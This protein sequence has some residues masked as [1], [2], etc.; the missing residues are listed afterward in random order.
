MAD[1][2]FKI[3]KSINLEPLAS[4]TLN[5]E[6]DIGVSSS[7]NQWKAYLGG[8]LRDVVTA[9]QA[10]TLTN[11]TIDGASNTI[12]GIGASALSD[13]SITTAKLSDAAVT[14]AK[15]SDGSITT[16]KL[17]SGITFTLSDGSVTT[18]KLSDEAVTTAKISD[19]SVSAAKLID[20]SVT[21][22]KLSDLAV[23]TA[24]LADA[25]VT[26]AKISDASVTA[27]KVSDASITT[28]KMGLDSYLQIPEIATPATPASG[29]GRIYFKSDGNL[30]QLNDGGVETSVITDSA[31]TQPDNQT[32]IGL[33]CSIAGGALTIALKQADGS[34]DPASGTGAVGISFRTSTATD[35][36]YVVRSVTSALSVVIPNAA[37]LG[38]VS[39]VNQYVWVYALD[40]AGTVE[41]AVSGVK[42]FQDNSI[43]SSTTM[44]TGSDFGNILYST[45]GR[46]NVAIR[47][48]G[49]ALVNQTVAGIWNAAPTLVVV[50]PNPQPAQTDYEDYTPTLTG[51]TT[52]A[53]TYAKHKRDGEDCVI[54]LKFSFGTVDANALTF[55]LPNS[56]QSSISNGA[57]IGT[58]GGA[59]AGGTYSG[60]VPIAGGAT[61]GAGAIQFGRNGGASIL[62][63]IISNSIANNN[64]IF[65]VSVRVPISGW[66]AFGPL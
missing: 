22:V 9:D 31:P 62:T 63:A 13:G 58:F 32:N 3:K 59:Y 27:A 38:H 1:N 61:A 6:G 37:V 29:Q 40:N 35:G 26:T 8:S 15:I 12:T 57:V 19:A 17:D 42:L 52:P 47:L 24:K 2:S 11:K 60:V 56:I 48:I 33:A 28:A 34:T 45:T 5:A 49:Q 16:A 41:L 36:A 43:Q 54:S 50:K 51:G 4:P 18:A 39:G 25:S 44:S 46:T 30:Y 7:D 14:T 20:E 23:S 53:I 21:A 64:D 65:T 10:Q 55:T 66:S